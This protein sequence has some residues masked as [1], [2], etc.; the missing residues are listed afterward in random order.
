MVRFILGICISWLLVSP[1]T[2]ADQTAQQMLVIADIHFSPFADC[3]SAKNCVLI[4]KLNQ[5]SASQWPQILA[6]Y[7][8][9]NRL[10]KNG[11]ATNYALFQSLLTQ[12]QTQKPENVII[13]GDFL[14]HR[15]RTL[16]LQSTHDHNR[17]HYNNF[18]LK[19]LQYLTS[20][21]QQVLPA[22][23]SVY[24]VIG[25]NDSVGGKDC[26]YSDYCVIT[27]GAFYKA[28]AN[29]WSALFSNN[30]NKSRFLATFPYAGYYEI[31]LPNTRDHILVLNTVL[32]ATKVQGPNV[33]KAA[34]AELNW[35]QQKLKEISDA[36]EKTWIVY[37][38]PPGIDAYSTAKNFLGVVVPFWDKEYS[39]PFLNLV[40]QYNST[41][42]GVL[43]GHTHMDGFLVLDLNAST[44]NVVDTFI[45]SVSPIFGNNPSF[46]TY[47]YS[48]DNFTIRNFATYYLDLRNK[49]FAW[50]KEYDFSS[51]FQPNDDLFTGY[52]KITANKDNPFST[53]YIQFYSVNTTSQPINQG[54]WDYYWCATHQ[55]NTKDYQNCLKK[56]TLL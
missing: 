21:I 50:Q 49:N 8:D 5:A 36:N 14:A 19:T 56:K 7:N 16:Y 9:P 47:S 32:F 2:A 38:I 17:D 23:S 6:N 52:Q 39:Q 46:K 25:N 22:D 1:A 11:Q 18:V 30:D 44:H 33:D 55:L 26:A 15:F 42:T 12:I 45:A 31:I 51:T 13:L 37:H 34:Q 27:N 41:I 35:L 53:D 43:S 40:H 10:P 54:K 28:L 20:S 3:P 4:S 29:Q 48:S 24:P